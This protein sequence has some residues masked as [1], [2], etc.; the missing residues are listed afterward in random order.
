MIVVRNL[1]DFKSHLI[2]RECSDNTILVYLLAVEQYISI[3][4]DDFS[5]MSLI[6]YKNYL[7]DNYAVSTVNLKILALNRYMQF[8]DI[9]H[10]LN[11]VKLHKVSSIDNIISLS[12]YY[13]LING[14]RSVGDYYHYYMVR[15]L[16]ETGCRVSELLQIRCD[17]IK[18]GY[19]DMFTKGKHRRLLIPKRLQ[20]DLMLY[21]SENNLT[22][23]LFNY[24][25]QNV[26]R[27]LKCFARNFGVSERVVYPHSF[28]HMFAIEFL[29]RN[30]DISL[31]SNILGHDSIATTQIYLRL[32]FNEQMERLNQT[33]DW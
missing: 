6:K 3:N 18:N 19:A 30:Q 31:L 24:S 21:I 2:E 14:L 20:D 16:G 26:Y 29:R 1:E 5:K 4:G 25:R 27:L 12:E 13:K 23:K 33:V 9:P 15:I 11:Y 10:R 8:L 28:R 32:T 7:K 22:D 17:D